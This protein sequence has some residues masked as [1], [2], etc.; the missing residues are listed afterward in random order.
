M[1]IVTGCFD[2]C[3]HFLGILLLLLLLLLP[4]LL[5]LLFSL[6]LLLLLLKPLVQ[7]G[8]KGFDVF[9]WIFPETCFLVGRC[10][11]DKGGSDS[12]AL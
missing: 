11:R 6:L 9:K 2:L 12:L 5:L 1:L 10:L 8:A 4:L 3:S 7:M